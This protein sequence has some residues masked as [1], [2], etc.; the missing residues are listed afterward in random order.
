ML[1]LTSTRFHVLPSLPSTTIITD[2]STSAEPAQQRSGTLHFGDETLGEVR[3]VLHTTIFFQSKYQKLLSIS[4]LPQYREKAG[5]AEMLMEQQ[6]P[7]DIS[8]RPLVTRQRE[9]YVTRDG[10]RYDYEPTDEILR[11]EEQYSYDGYSESNGTMISEDHI[12]QIWSKYG[13]NSL[14]Q[15][16][17]IDPHTLYIKA[18]KLLQAA[19]HG[20]TDD[21]GIYK[22]ISFAEVMKN[23]RPDTSLQS[24]HV[25]VDLETSEKIVAQLKNTNLTNTFPTKRRPRR[26]QLSSAPNDVIENWFENSQ[27]TIGSAYPE[28]LLPK[29]KRLF[30]TYRDLH[31]SSQLEVVPTDLYTHRVRLT[32]GTKPH[33]DMR[34]IRLNDR[35]RYWLNKTVEEGL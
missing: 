9:Y 7:I 34:E 26:R 29:V 14:L 19:H 24:Y 12:L 30:Y 21:L 20:E 23:P 11:T 16:V 13:E 3:Q 17:H 33:N 15:H 1:L 32:P 18:W 6:T 10:R 27:L 28:H 8:T 5:M 35:Q 22:M 25:E 31:A 4:D 2:T